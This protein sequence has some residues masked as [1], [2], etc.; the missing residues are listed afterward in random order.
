MASSKD[1]FRAL[2][3]EQLTD[4][5]EFPPPAVFARAMRLS[6][7]LGL[8]SR[9]APGSVV[10]SGARRPLYAAR[11]ARLEHY[12]PVSVIT[13]GQ[14]LNITVQSY[15]DRLDF[16]LICDPD[17]VP[18]VDAMLDAI[19]ADLAAL[20]RSAGFTPADGADSVTTRR[21]QQV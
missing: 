2:P 4:F 17:L 20:A 9:L 16:G 18:D 10:I 15:L 7:R 1:I 8:G 14:G 11:G 5:A 19:L 12:F 6:A 21:R 13:E 3:A